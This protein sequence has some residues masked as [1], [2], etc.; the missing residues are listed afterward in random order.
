MFIL[1]GGISL[2][3]LPRRLAATP[4]LMGALYMTRGQEF[5]IGV[6]FSVV[7]VLVTVGVLRVISKG[8]RIEGG[9]NQV[10]LFLILCAILLVVTSFFHT[11]DSL[12]YRLGVIWT[13]LGSYFLFRVFIQDW[14][15]VRHVFKILC[16]ILVPVAALM[17]LEKTIGRNYFAVLLGGI[18]EIP[19]LRD[20]HYRCQGPFDHPILAG[21]VGATCFPIALYFWRSNRKYALVG[22]FSAAGIVFAATSS[23]PIMMTLFSL[24]GLCM[25]K[26]RKHLAVIRWFAL[27]VIIALDA[28]MK[29]PVY[30]LMAR[31]D[32]SGGS[33]GWYR[34]QLIRSSIEHLN[35]WWLTGTD[36]TRHWMATGIYSNSVHTDITNH[37]LA[38]GVSAGLPMIFLF[39]S[40]LVAAFRLVGKTLQ[41]NE[42]APIEHRFLAWTLGAIL[43]GHVWNFFTISLFGQSVVFLYFILACISAVHVTK[44]FAE[45]ER[46]QKQSVN[47]IRQ[48]IYVSR[49]G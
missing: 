7:R 34:A 13:E 24:L 35:E 20:G 29:D 15:D 17:L 9:M 42:N 38:M 26:V 1:V 27:V 33:T 2:F 46:R 5:D 30:F 8:E 32:L 45:T 47:R 18:S 28:I 25:W 3:V 43:F 40:A 37:F 11:S 10:D 16:I 12:V 44:S 19:V 22:L 14:E 36:H 48:S 41:E 49:L 4:L 6:H 31:I 23:G 39:I 21:T